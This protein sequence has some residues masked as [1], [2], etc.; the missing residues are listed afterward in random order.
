MN[1]I[2]AEAEGYVTLP[3]IESIL[4]KNSDSNPFVI[5]EVVANKADASLGYLVKGEEPIKDGKTLHDMPTK[6][7]RSMAMDSFGK[8]I[9]D[10]TAGDVLKSLISNGALSYSGGYAETDL[11]A[12]TNLMEVYGQFVGN[13]DG[14]YYQKV[15][16]NAFVPYVEGETTG[17]RYSRYLDVNFSSNGKNALTFKYF[18]T[19]SQKNITYNGVDYHMYFTYYIPEGGVTSLDSVSDYTQKS[20]SYVYYINEDVDGKINY[21]FYGIMQSDG[22]IRDING[23]MVDPNVLLKDRYAFVSFE[24]TFLNGEYVYADIKDVS[25]NNDETNPIY[26]GG[27]NLDDHYEANPSSGE[28]VKVEDSVYDYIPSYPEYVKDLENYDYQGPYSFVGNRNFIY[29]EFSINNG[30]NNNDWFK[31]Y[32]LDLS[33]SQKDSHPVQV[34]SV[35]MDE[36]N[37]GNYISETSLIYLAAGSYSTDIESDKARE[38]VKEVKNRSLPIVV[39]SSFGSNLKNNQKLVTMLQQVD[40][41]SD[42]ASKVLESKENW[43]NDINW[44]NLGSTIVNNKKDGTSYSYVN[45]N[46]FIYEDRNG[47]QPLV[48]GDFKS[49][50][51]DKTGFSKV[52]EEIETENTYRKIGQ[53]QGVDYVLKGEH[54]VVSKATVIR[55]IINY[56]HQRVTTKPEI[57]VLEI[58]P[59]YSFEE[60]YEQNKTSSDSSLYNITV[61]NSSTS[62]N[63]INHEILTEQIVAG[64]LNQTY[65]KSNIDLTQTYTKEF[66]GKIEDLN[67]TYDVIYIGLDTT[68]MNTAVV[69]KTKTNKTLYNDSENLN[70]VIYSHLGDLVVGNNDVLKWQDGYK[71][72][73]RDARQYRLSGNDITYEKYVN[74]LEYIKA[75]YAVVFADD[76]FSYMEVDG[77]LVITGVND[78]SKKYKE[79]NIYIG[80]NSGNNFDLTYRETELGKGDYWRE[81][82]YK[83]EGDHGGD[84][85][86][87]SKYSYNPNGSYRVNTKSYVGVGKGDYSYSL[88]DDVYKYEGKNKGDYSVSFKNYS[89]GNYKRYNIETIYEEVG[90]GKGSYSLECVYHKCIGEEEK[91]TKGKYEIAYS[92]GRGDYLT[93]YQYVENG[94]VGKNG[95]I[96]GTIDPNSYMYSLASFVLYEKDEEGKRYIDKNVFVRSDLE[97]FSKKEVISNFAKYVNTSKLLVKCEDGDTPTEYSV[98]ADGSNPNYLTG[99]VLNY[100]VYLQNNGIYA[101]DSITYDAGLYIDTSTDGR[102]TENEKLTYMSV[103][104][105]SVTPANK[106]EKDAN[107]RYNLKTGNTYYI[108]VNLPNGYVGMLPWKLVFSQNPQ[109][110]KDTYS[111]LIRRSISGYTAVEKSKSEKEDIKVLQLIGE[112]HRITNGKQVTRLWLN[113]KNV[114]K[115]LEKVNDFNITVDVVDVKNLIN[116]SYTTTSN[117]SYTNSVS[118]SYNPELTKPTGWQYT[119][120]KSDLWGNKDAFNVLTTYTGSSQEDFFKFFNSY[121]MII[122]GFSDVIDFSGT[123]QDNE[124]EANLV[125]RNQNAILA[126]NQY[127]ESGKSILFTHDSTSR[128]NANYDNDTKNILNNWNNY[129]AEYKW[130]YYFNTYIRNIVGMDRYNVLGDDPDSMYDFLATPNDTKN[131]NWKADSSKNNSKTK[132]SM[133]YTDLELFNRYLKGQSSQYQLTCRHDGSDYDGQ[134]DNSKYQYYAT[135]VNDGQIT[136]YPFKIPEK[137]KISL[138]HNQYYQLN[139]DTYSKDEEIDDDIVVWYCISDVEDSGKKMDDIYQMTPN[140]VRNN[141]YIYTKGNITYSGAGHSKVNTTGTDDELAE[142]RLFINTMV[143]A[144]KAGIHS[145]SIVY[146]DADSDLAIDTTYVPYDRTEGVYLPDSYDDKHNGEITLYFEITDTNIVQG[147]RVLK[148]EFKVI[149]YEKEGAEVKGEYYNIPAKVYN[150]DKDNKLSKDPVLVIAGT[151]DE[152]FSNALKANTRYAI[153]I[154]VDD[155]K[156]TGDAVYPYVSVSL[157]A[158]V[159]YI[160][161]A[162]NVVESGWGECNLQIRRLELFDL[163]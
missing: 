88:S 5:V 47:T 141:Y 22:K 76:F 44:S 27:F 16:F 96:R 58:E 71:D 18:T 142:L 104:R 1:R 72:S 38:L 161:S 93:Y 107:G 90:A 43:E 116:K 80:A 23:A 36:F 28:Y 53:G 87:V 9:S 89:G 63:K 85:K 11:N 139:L 54:A 2:T 13:A 57:K 138:T 81:E 64:W 34:I 26:Y 19:A 145:P 119:G 120:T 91:R 144:Y 37:K 59:C 152:T 77:Q 162:T 24:K 31:E 151:T 131:D 114:G 147:E 21:V 40:L 84:W 149:N 100:R 108:Q 45:N 157:R 33:A 66:I 83:Y 110:D 35:T 79:Q 112:N 125:K 68:T 159:Q 52:A 130:G 32:V 101:A 86:Q 4:M 117:K 143:A 6:V 103:Y 69:D 113:D 154:K 92:E 30:I 29:D 153:K 115:Q 20:G 8:K 15:P 127:I 65:E 56:A 109:G 61:K 146:H 137:L 97:C 10:G 150:V 73:V 7:E 156:F 94:E 106:E 121:D 48:Y 128:F 3:G 105:G 98:N 78:A 160:Q 129:S 74:L 95:V 55:Y 126:L 122:V 124:S 75:G 140:D 118:L 155:L 135:Q 67:E 132:L 133:G 70:G 134:Y 49:E 111:K 163:K 42:N 25:G 14:E 102:Y 123:R 99:N 62:V 82:N 17:E 12:G 39:D 158:K 51:S 148:N 46:I 136:E 60:Y 41:G 50:L